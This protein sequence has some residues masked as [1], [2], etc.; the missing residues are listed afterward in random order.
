MQRT[1][2]HFIIDREGNIQSVIKGA[3]GGGC[4]LLTA[5]IK[6]LGKTILESSTGEF[7]EDEKKAVIRTKKL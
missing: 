2:M 7:Y 6:K 5:D 1:E 4:K 3:K